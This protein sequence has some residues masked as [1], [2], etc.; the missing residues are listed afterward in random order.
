MT[1]R[2]LR[3]LKKPPA[4][5][6]LCNDAGCF[7]LQESFIETF[8]GLGRS[9]EPGSSLDQSVK[10]TGIW[11]AHEEYEPLATAIETAI[12]GRLTVQLHPIR[13]GHA[14]TDDGARLI[15][16]HKN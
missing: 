11:T 14:A 5:W 2:P 9:E 8:K 16:G 3:K 12:N 10:G 6:I 4:L 7:D 15:I 1:L 13:A